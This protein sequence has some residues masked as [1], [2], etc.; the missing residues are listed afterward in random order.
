MMLRDTVVLGDDAY[1]I[2]DIMNDVTNSPYA[3]PH[4]IFF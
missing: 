2:S 3:A 4:L 1:H